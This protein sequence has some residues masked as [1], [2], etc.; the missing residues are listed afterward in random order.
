MD[1][2]STTPMTDTKPVEAIEAGQTVILAST[3]EQ[4]SLIQTGGDNLAAFQQAKSYLTRTDAESS[5]VSQHADSYVPSSAR[6]IAHTREDRAHALCERIADGYSMASV[7]GKD[8]LPSV[9]SFLRWCHDEPLLGN[10]YTVALRI[11]AAGMAEKLLELCA[12]LEQ[13][14]LDAA[15][16]SAV[17]VHI[18]TLQWTMSRLLPKQYGDHQ[19][20]EHT[21]EVKLSG[22]ELDERLKYLLSKAQQG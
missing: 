15:T 3:E 17:K 2:S 12:K 13:P 11:R 20:I 4:N 7:A 19:V 6:T 18:N 10:M 9:A 1:H 22:K 16:V 5:M 14:G 21:G 8:G